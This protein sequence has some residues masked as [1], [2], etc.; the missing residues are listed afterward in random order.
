MKLLKKLK[1][2]QYSTVPV[3]VEMS[4]GMQQSMAKPIRYRNTDGNLVSAWL[5]GQS[6]ATNMMLVSETRNA[7]N[8][9]E[10]VQPSRVRTS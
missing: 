10:L 8:G 4:K 7:S 6:M 1:S 3:A 2:K 9:Y 5:I